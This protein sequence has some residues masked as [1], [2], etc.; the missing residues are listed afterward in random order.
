MIGEDFLATKI[1]AIW[2]QP[3]L[4]T[5]GTKTDGQMFVSEREQETSMRDFIKQP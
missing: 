5:L 4:K 2:L 1:P 3:I